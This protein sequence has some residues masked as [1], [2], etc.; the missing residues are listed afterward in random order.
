MDRLTRETDPGFRLKRKMAASFMRCHP[1]QA[2]NNLWQSLRKSQVERFRIRRQHPLAGYIVNFYCPALKLVIEVDGSIH[3]RI[4]ESD[5]IR[6]NDLVS[7]EYHVL[8]I[9]NDEVFY[10]LDDTVA[11]IR[12]EVSNLCHSCNKN[13]DEEES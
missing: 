1:T 3:E 10:A 4:R 5:R 7:R 8:R 12:T 6:Q 11:K 9:I 2:E 13:Q